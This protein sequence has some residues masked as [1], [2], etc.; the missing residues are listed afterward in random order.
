[1]TDISFNEEIGEL[2]YVVACVGISRLPIQIQSGLN[3]IDLFSRLY[4]S[5]TASEVLQCDRYM[6]QMDQI[7]Q[8]TI[9]ARVK[10][11]RERMGV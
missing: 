7:D 9:N 3:S 1:M 11:I 5:L 6:A 4:D 2:P 8:E 10:R